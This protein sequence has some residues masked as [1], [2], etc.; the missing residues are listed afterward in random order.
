MKKLLIAAFVAV[1]CW[2]PLMASA[3]DFSGA[4]VSHSYC[5][6]EPGNLALSHSPSEAGSQALKSVDASPAM[7][8]TILASLSHEGS[9]GAS[10]Q[11]A[12]A[13]TG[14]A[15]NSPNASNDDIGTGTVTVSAPDEVGWQS[16]QTS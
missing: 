1:A 12:S 10:Y 3:S 7:G 4:G 11:P 6:H 15:N 16:I 8:A 5:N 9:P 14:Q 13:V 2:A